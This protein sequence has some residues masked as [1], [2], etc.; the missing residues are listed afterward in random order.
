MP[1]LPGTVDDDLR[2][3]IKAI[4]RT[5]AL[6]E[7]LDQCLQDMSAT[8]AKGGHYFTPR[9]VARLMVA[10]VAPQDGHRIYDPVCGSAGLLIDSV[11]HVY[12]RTGL[13]AKLSLTGQDLHAGTLQIAQMNLAVHGVEAHL[14]LPVDSLAQPT[15][16]SY[17]IVLAN[18]PFNMAPWGPEP[19]RRGDPR[20][21]DDAP[22]PRDNANHAWIL[23]IA[24]ALAPQGR[25]AILMADGAATGVRPIDR[26]IRE[27]LIRDDLVEC[28]V[29]LPPGLFPHTRISCC[30]WVLNRDKRPH[31]EWGPS[32]RRDMVL[33]IDARKAYETTGSR[34]QRRLTPEGVAKIRHTLDA[35]R[36]SATTGQPHAAYQDEIGWCHAGSGQEIVVHEHDLLPTLYTAEPAAEGVVERQLVEELTEELYSRFDEA[37]ALERDLRHILDGL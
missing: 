34:R 24:H 21:P 1:R 30:L 27:Q 28:V 7:L 25:A 8:Q 32:D 33:F 36:G 19:L 10:L 31:V 16:A 20:W 12:E 2:G 22:P 14:E 23:H 37:H 4:D 18:P 13:D 3:L 29:A 26:R 15:N 35:W 5:D 11:R 6:G 17:D 9:G